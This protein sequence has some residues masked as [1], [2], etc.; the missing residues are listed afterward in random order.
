MGALCRAAAPS[1]F[2]TSGLRFL[3]RGVAYDLRMPAVATLRA[4]FAAQWQPWLT[5]QDRQK[6]NPHITVQNKVAPEQA[7]QSLAALQASYTP[8]RGQVTG[9][10]LWRYEGGPWAELASWEFSGG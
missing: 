3:G 2:E 5:P 8:W 9:L 10:A 7:Q 1:A 6:F 4:Q